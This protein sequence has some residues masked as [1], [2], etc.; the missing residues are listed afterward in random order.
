MKKQILIVVALTGI[1]SL[2]SGS[3][4][5]AFAPQPIEEDTQA[6]D[7]QQTPGNQ[8]VTQKNF[9]ETNA[10]LTTADTGKK[11]EPAPVILRITIVDK[12]TD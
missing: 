2:L 11:Q 12:T 3:A 8:P 5:S 6:Y 9:A 1:L 4:W 7:Q 10:G